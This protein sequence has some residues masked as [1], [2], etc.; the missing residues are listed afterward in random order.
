MLISEKFKDVNLFELIDTIEKLPFEGLEGLNNY[1]LAKYGERT[2]IHTVTLISNEGIADILHSI[3]FDK[4][5][6]LYTMYSNDVLS[7]GNKSETTTRVTIDNGENNSTITG[8]NLHK[9]SAFDEDNLTDDNSDSESRTTKDTSKNDTKET[10]TTTGKSA[11][12]TND[13]ITY[14]KYLTTNMYY[15]S[16]CLD[17]INVISSSTISLD[18]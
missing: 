7:E 10:V 12:Y 4:W 17:I 1:W 8:E 6:K 13:F 5:T 11:N 2:I 3:F 16:I 14:N 9:V 15:D 18:V